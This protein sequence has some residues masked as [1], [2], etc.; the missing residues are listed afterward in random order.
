M[1]IIYPASGID[2]D[3]FSCS[4]L[5]SVI[6]PYMGVSQNNDILTTLTYKIVKVS[7]WSLQQAVCVTRAKLVAIK[8]EKRT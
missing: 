1:C 8:Q 5:D 4:V 6:S 7:Y 3:C 2:V